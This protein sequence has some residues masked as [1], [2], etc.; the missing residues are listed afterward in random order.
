[1]RGNIDA[2]AQGAEPDKK[3]QQEDEERVVDPF[4]PPDPHA[5]PLLPLEDKQLSAPFELSAS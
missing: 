3:Q 1:M 4:N 5:P 2:C